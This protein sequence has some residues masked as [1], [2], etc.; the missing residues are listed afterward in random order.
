M[1]VWRPSKF[2]DHT[3]LTE[4][5]PRATDSA[6]LGMLKVTTVQSEKSLNKYS[7]VG[8]VWKPARCRRNT[9]VRLIKPRGSW[10][11]VCTYETKESE[12]PNAAYQHKRLS[13]C[14][15]DKKQICN[16]KGN[17][18]CNGPRQV[19]VCNRFPGRLQCIHLNLQYESGITWA[20][21]DQLQFSY[22]SR[23]WCNWK[24]P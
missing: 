10:N 18:R 8:R 5:S 14:A 23:L 24:F 21:A 12:Q 6:G 7:L 1:I 11:N 17:E 2:P 13:N 15:W 3:V 19:R 16:R 22:I 20:T 9:T 4:K